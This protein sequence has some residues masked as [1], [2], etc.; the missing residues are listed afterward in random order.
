MKTCYHILEQLSIG[1]P[2]TCIYRIYNEE[3]T[4]YI[5]K[6]VDETNDVE[7]LEDYFGVEVIELFIDNLVG[8]LEIINLVRHSKVWELENSTEIDEDIISRLTPEKQLK[9]PAY[10]KPERPRASFVEE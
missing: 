3:R 4:K 6:L 5:M 2:E 1:F 7:E 9:N 10:K 8:Q